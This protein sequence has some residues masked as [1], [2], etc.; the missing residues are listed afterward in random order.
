ME[1]LDQ[2]KVE[3]VTDECC[4]IVDGSREHLPPAL[5]SQV[6]LNSADS[7]NPSTSNTTFIRP[8]R[9]RSGGVSVRI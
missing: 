6:G 2:G 9:R 4:R 7:F 3:R 5:L 1:N 8:N